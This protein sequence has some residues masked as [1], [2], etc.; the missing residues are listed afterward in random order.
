MTEKSGPSKKEIARWRQQLLRVQRI[1]WRDLAATLGPVILI[2][3]AAIA[4]TLHFVRPAP[5]SR[6]VMAG[7]AESSNF[8]AV[9]VKYKAIL[10]RNGI[11]LEIVPSK[12]SLDNLGMLTDPDSGVDIA[13]VQA[14]VTTKADTSDLISLG[15]MFPQPLIVFYRSAKPVTRLSELEGKRLAI[16]GEGTGTRF[17]AL[18]LL[19]ANGIEP[20]DKTTL[21]DLEGEDARKALLSRQVDA[22]FLS[23]DSSSIAILRELMHADAVRLF[24]F[25]QADAY[26]R[27]FRY[28]S[29]LQLPAGTFDLGENLPPQPLTMLAPSVELLAH[30]ELHPA[31]SDLLVEAAHEVHGKGTLLANPGEFPSPA[32]H[33]YPIGNDAARYYKSGKGI[34]YRYL[35]FWLAS[36]VSRAA[37]ILVPVLVVLIPGLRYAP[38]LYGWRINSRIYKRYGELMT[39][40]RAALQP[41]TPE[42]RAA[43]LTR[44]DEIEKAI[45]SFNTPGAFADQIYVLRRHIRFVRENLAQ[46]TGSGLAHPAN[47]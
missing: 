46:N 24:D 10:A 17:L 4:A 23:G 21:L 25:V 13:L 30:S 28:L 16:G 3:A 1:S 14:G 11:D 6:L 18:A 20:G 8:R 26:E 40:E 27:R 34:A 45:I 15:S 42:Q 43:L 29:K 33:D 19:K 7:G 39:L 12:G 36:L 22:I 41:I 35:P 37:V 5:P 38:N 9:A 32:Q 44:L 47:P 2:S 31:L